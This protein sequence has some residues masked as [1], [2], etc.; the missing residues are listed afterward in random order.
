LSRQCWVLNISKPKRPPQPITAI[1]LLYFTSVSTLSL[2][3]VRV[4]N[5]HS[6]GRI[7]RKKKTGMNTFLRV[8][9]DGLLKILLNYRSRKHQHIGRPIARWMV[10]FFRSG[11]VANVYILGRGGGGWKEENFSIRYIRPIF[12]EITSNVT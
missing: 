9:P 4:R 3:A 12:K 7:E 2:H 10:I 11:K 8:T 1:P 5:T 6:T